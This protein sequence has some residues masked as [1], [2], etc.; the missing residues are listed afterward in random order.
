MFLYLHKYYNT[1]IPHTGVTSVTKVTAFIFCSLSTCDIS[2]YTFACIFS[3][4]FLL[5]LQ[6]QQL[7]LNSCI[8]SLHYVLITIRV[9]YMLKMTI[10]EINIKIL[11]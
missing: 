8:S 11:I 2:F 1:I 7:V 10:K 9:I 6:S 3:A 4:N 5:T